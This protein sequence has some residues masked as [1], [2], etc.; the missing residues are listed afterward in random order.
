MHCRAILEDFGQKQ[1]FIDPVGVRTP[2]R[3]ARSLVAIPTTLLRLH[4]YTQIAQ[5]NNSNDSLKTLP[6][7]G[8]AHSNSHVI[9]V[10]GSERVT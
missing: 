8:L 9:N 5:L 3:T 2:D 6:Q 1:K 10:R 7:S 4:V